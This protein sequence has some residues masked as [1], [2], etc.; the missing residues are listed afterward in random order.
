MGWE[1]DLQL[2]LRLGLGYPCVHSDTKHTYLAEMFQRVD[3]AMTPPTVHS[4]ITYIT[5]V[6][7]PSPAGPHMGAR[8][9]MD[10]AY[11]EIVSLL[12]TL[13]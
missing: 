3:Q 9:A 12:K 1:V 2:C 8:M 13:S 11:H 7:N 10:A 5:R 4:V 6:P